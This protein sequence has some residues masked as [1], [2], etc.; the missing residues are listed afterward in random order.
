MKLPGAP[1]PRSAWIER[2]DEEHANPR[3]VWK[4]MGEP[5]YLCPRQVQQMETASL[6]HK[7]PQRWKRESD[8]LHFATVDDIRRNTYILGTGWDDQC[9]GQNQ[10]LDRIMS[11]KG[12][13][14]KLYILG[15]VELA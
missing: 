10:N 7:A 12:I 6:L 5:E 1:L 4:E 11:E 14:H 13:P 3:R 15:H 2:I 9:L 8:S